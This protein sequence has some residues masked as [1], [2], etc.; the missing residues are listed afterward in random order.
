[1]ARQIIILDKLPVASGSTG[2]QV[3]YRA[4]VPA[5]RQAFYVNPAAVSA[6]KDATP[7]E[8]TD[9][10]TGAVVER[11]EPYV[12]DGTPTLNAVKAALQARFTDFQTSVTNYNPWALYGSS[13]DGTVWTI[14]GVG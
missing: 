12:I 8:T 11:V 14:G 13:W 3:L 6:Y 2:Y 10:Q 5:A 7:Q 1:M 4:V 9:L